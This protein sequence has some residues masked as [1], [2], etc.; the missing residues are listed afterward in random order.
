LNL[1]PSGYEPDELPGCSTPRRLIRNLRPLGP[2][3]KER[4]TGG[5]GGP[6][7]DL[8]FRRLSGSTIGAEGFHGRVR[9]GIGWS[10]PR[11]G[12]QVFG[13]QRSEVRTSEPR[14]GSVPG[15]RSCRSAEA[16]CVYVSSWRKGLPPSDIWFLEPGSWN[17]MVLAAGCGRS[18]A[19]SD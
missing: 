5:L 13:W 8:L 3:R 4:E 15:L 19:S 10:T 2:E 14:G 11:Y 12:R 1:R 18:S 17:L 6:G 16:S 9:D 7:G